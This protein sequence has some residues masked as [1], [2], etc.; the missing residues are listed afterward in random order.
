MAVLACEQRHGRRAHP[1]TR[2]RAARRDEHDAIIALLLD[3]N[4]EYR[5]VLPARVF[6]AYMQTLRDLVVDETARELM[7]ADLNDHIL[8]IIAFHPDASRQ[9]WGLPK[10]W[11][12][13]RALAVDPTARGRGIGRQLAEACVLRAWRIGAPVACLHTSAFHRTARRLYDGMGFVRSPDHDLDVSRSAAG[14]GDDPRGE[15]LTI[16]AYRLDLK[17]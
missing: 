12:G 15:R 17:A 5:D 8:G 2:I 10:G 1:D 4:R 16:E 13:L 7:V 14:G 6:Y 3:A 9:S 11:A